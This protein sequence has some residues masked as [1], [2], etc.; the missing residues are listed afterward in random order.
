MNM[1]LLKRAHV[2][3]RR[4]TQRELSAV[5]IEIFLCSGCHIPPWLGTLLHHSTVI[6]PWLYLMNEA[7]SPVQ[8]HSFMPRRGL[9]P[10]GPGGVR[11]LHHPFCG[12]G[13]WPGTKI[14]APQE[15]EPGTDIQTRTPCANNGLI[16]ST[17][18][19]LK[20]QLSGL[21]KKRV[22]WC[23][24]GSKCSSIW[25]YYWVKRVFFGRICHISLMMYTKI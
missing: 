24:G 18:P 9:R 11:T 16:Q 15:M 25:L 17:G 14:R 5:D 10:L 23:C 20:W 1:S 12:G 19:F 7:S 2:T 21:I 4:P 22:V 3:E 13:L 6:S 8:V